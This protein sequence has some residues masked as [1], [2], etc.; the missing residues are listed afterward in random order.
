MK[1]ILHHIDF[2]KDGVF[3]DLSFDGEKLFCFTLEHA[4][5]QNDGTYATK[6]PNGTYPPG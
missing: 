6:I 5:E 3:G 2:N 4:Y 1:L